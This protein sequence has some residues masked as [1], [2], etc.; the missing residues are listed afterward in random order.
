MLDITEFRTKPHLS[1]SSVNDYLDCGLLYKL[2]RIDKIQPEFRSDAMELG[3]A[4]HMTFAEFYKRKMI[5]EKMLL[6]E[7]QESFEGFWR[8]LAEDNP[9]IQYSEGKDFDTL[10]REGEELLAV[11]YTKA[12]EN[13][14]KVIGVEEPFIVHIEGLAVPLIG[15]I[16]L[17]EEDE[18]GTIIITDTKTSGRSYSIDEVDKNMQLTLYQIA[19]KAN[20]FRDREILLKFDALIKTRTPKFEQFYTS[21]SEIEEKRLIKKIQEVWRGIHQ[22]IFIPNDG[23]NNW[24]CKNCGF[25]KQ[26]DAFLEGG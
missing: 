21:R 4:I 2:S 20:G 25:K 12:P 6:K 5:G 9:N 26:C 8:E 3:S 15:Y 11:W 18:S 22:Q 7:I 13:D 19:V 24:K 14:F 16:D 1:A 10:L 17:L 23:P